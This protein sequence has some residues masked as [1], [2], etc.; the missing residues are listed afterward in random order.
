MPRSARP[1][2]LPY[3]LL[4]SLLHR[5]RAKVKLGGDALR[6]L[7]E[8]HVAVCVGIEGALNFD[9]LLM[10]QHRAALLVLIQACDGIAEREAGALLP[11]GEDFEKPVYR[12]GVAR[13][14]EGDASKQDHYCAEQEDK[15]RRIRACGGTA[16]VAWTRSRG[17]QAV[18]VNRRSTAGF[19]PTVRRRGAQLERRTRGL[20]RTQ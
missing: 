5:I 20:S 7:C 6:L 1:T 16:A 8:R 13:G 3:K 9:G 15:Q 4:D 2:H 11:V 14:C 19:T 12:R 17:R 18:G 10:V